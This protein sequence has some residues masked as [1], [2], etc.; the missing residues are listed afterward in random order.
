MGLLSRRTL[1]WL[2]VLSSAL[3]FALSSYSL[4]LSKLLPAPEHRVLMH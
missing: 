4:I 3:V 1:G 2:L